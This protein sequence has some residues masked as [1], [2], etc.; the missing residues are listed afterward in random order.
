[1]D[2]DSGGVNSRVL[3]LLQDPS[4]TATDTRF[5]SPDNNDSTA[6]CTTDACQRGGL[7][8][9]VRLHWNVYPWWV[10][11]K[12]KGAPRDPSRP[13]D[14]WPNASRV[15]ARLW[16]DFFQLLPGLRVVVTFGKRTREGWFDAVAEGLRVP[17]GV[18]VLHAGSLSP[19]GGYYRHRDQVAG[20][21]AD[22][23]RLAGA[24]TESNRSQR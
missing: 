20:T 14:T 9:S 3:L 4:R 7:V 6:R 15:A 12:D 2:P 5:I 17:R 11:T 19:L 24:V 18:E 22:A 13:L 21:I 23:A 10:N 16:G 1:M 8:R